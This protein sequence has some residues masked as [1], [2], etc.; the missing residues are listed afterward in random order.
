MERK[1]MQ[2]ITMEGKEIPVID[3]REVAEM[4]EKTHAHLM[5]DIKGYIEV[6][7]NL[8]K[9]IVAETTD[10]KMKEGIELIRKQVVDIMTNLKVEKIA[11]INETFNP[12]IHEAV[13]HIEDDKY[14][15]KEIVEEFRSGYK[16]GNSVLRHAMVKVAN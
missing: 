12:E 10:E 3:S 14:G 8:E 6:L 7:D 15:E 5:R 16:M 1:E 9:A 13:M 11:T 2:T 4:V